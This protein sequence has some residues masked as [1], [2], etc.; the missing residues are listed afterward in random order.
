M[1]ITLSKIEIKNTF[2]FG[3]MKHC[4]KIG[5]ITN[6]GTPGF[7]FCVSSKKFKRAVDR[8]KIKRMMRNAVQGVTPKE[9][10]VLIYFGTEVPTEIKIKL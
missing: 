8:N 7:G 10:I 2:A 9:S 3:K 1:K 5:I 4:G 6:E